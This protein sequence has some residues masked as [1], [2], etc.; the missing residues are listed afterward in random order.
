MKKSIL[1]LLLVAILFYPT[2]TSSAQGNE[3]L[4]FGNPEPGTSEY[5]SGSF[6][7]L[8][9]QM[10]ERERSQSLTLYDEINNYAY[11][12]IRSG[13][14][15]KIVKYFLGD[16]TRPAQR[17]GAT[18]LNI[19]WQSI[20]LGFIDPE[21]GVAYLVTRGQFQSGRP[22]AVTR[23]SLGEGDELP[24]VVGWTELDIDDLKLGIGSGAI[25][26]K[27]GYGYI[28]E[29]DPSFVLFPTIV[30]SGEV[31]MFKLEGENGLPERVGKITLGENERNI[32]NTLV[33]QENM[34][35][36]FFNDI[37]PSSL[38]KYKI[39][40]NG[41]L[42]TR[43]GALEI[44]VSY[45]DS[46]IG[47]I[48]FDTGYGVFLSTVRID[49]SNTII[50]QKIHVG[51]DDDLP[52]LVSQAHAL[53][54]SNV[55]LYDPGSM[56]N[57]FFLE[58]RN[59]IK[60]IQEVQIGDDDSPPEIV[61]FYRFEDIQ[62][63][64]LSNI[65]NYDSESDD[66]TLLIES[67]TIGF[68]NIN[69]L[70]EDDE[71]RITSL[72]A[73]FHFNDF[74]HSIFDP[75][76]DTFYLAR[77]LQDTS[78]VSQPPPFYTNP[79]E[80]HEIR[81]RG[82]SL[83]YGR[84]F[85][86]VS[87][88]FHFDSN[89]NR[90][91]TASMIDSEN[92]LAFMV[93][94]GEPSVLISYRLGD[95][96]S[97]ISHNGEVEI[98]ETESEITGGFIDLKSYVLYLTTDASP[99]EILSY[100]YDPE[101]NNQP[102]FLSNLN[103]NEGQ[104]HIST[105]SFD[106]ENFV[107][108]HATFT[109]PSMIVKVQHLPSEGSMEVV[110]SILLN[111]P[112]PYPYA[113]D[114]DLDNNI[115]I[116]AVGSEQSRIV[117][118]DLGN[119]DGE[120][121]V[122]SS[123]PIETFVN[124]TPVSLLIN[125]NNNEFYLG[126]GQILQRYRYSSFEQS[127]EFYGYWQLQHPIGTMAFTPDMD[128]L[129]VGST[130]RFTRFPPG[131][132][133]PTDTYY[134]PYV[135][136]FETTLQDKVFGDRIH[137][138]DYRKP[139]SLNFYSYEADG[140]LDFAIYRG[141]NNLELIWESGLI[142]NTAEEDFVTV[143]FED[144]FA[145]Q[146]GYYWLTWRTSS[147]RS[148]ASHVPSEADTGFMI[149]H[150]F[151]DSFPE[152]IQLASGRLYNRNWSISLEADYLTPPTP[153]PTPIP[154]PVPS[155][156]PIPTPE[157]NPVWAFTEQSTFTEDSA[158][159]WTFSSPE[160]FN[161]PNGIR[162]NS[163]LEVHTTANLNQ[164]GFWERMNMELPVEVE[165]YE[166]MLT[167]FFLFSTWA[168]SVAN[169]VPTFRLR[170]HSAD[171]SEGYLLAI[172][173]SPSHPSFY[174]NRSGK[175]Y[176]LFWHHDANEPFHHAFDAMR[177]TNQIPNSSMVGMEWFTHRKG[178]LNLVADFR[179]ELS[180]DFRG[181]ESL[182]WTAVHAEPDLLKPELF[183]LSEKGLGIQATE[184][185]SEI[186]DVTFGFWKSAVGGVNSVT[187]ESG[188]IYRAKFTVSSDATESEKIQLPTFR[189]RVNAMNTTNGQIVTG[190]LVNIESTSFDA[191]IATVESPQVYEIWIQIPPE[192]DGN[193]LIFSFDYLYVPGIGND[194][195]MA[196]ILES[197]EVDSFRIPDNQQHLMN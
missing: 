56:D 90:P 170:S 134:N 33:D 177:F 72:P 125:S 20:S 96:P 66:L 34:Y 158:D 191:R 193:R 51:D 82:K 10:L 189:G 169:L 8:E 4:I 138:M 111:E 157:P 121:N 85:P 69:D 68:A 59:Q 190:A 13:S 42:P 124:Q 113:M 16:E 176:H 129:L 140:N 102:E 3:L 117:M 172:E 167:S 188:R 58:T 75:V 160:D 5:P 173:T 166:F 181:G 26:W 132:M 64:R 86:P 19:P 35:V 148:V 186:S 81:L 142:P 97:S 147:S 174:P 187:A 194:P 163:K 136:L 165:P 17:L 151:N 89:I 161:S 146:P 30:R 159:G 156:T 70:N 63:N 52:R 183:F 184:S 149:H 127:I 74:R 182:G 7:R 15:R 95:H 98:V 28:S 80:V 71:I 40:D 22:P 21:N 144:D 152:S 25:D 168:D 196:I 38:V 106:H 120:F 122:F 92:R 145:L 104:D 171:F 46:G 131:F 109:S 60:T 91:I 61:N 94:D 65:I 27:N 79:Q 23:I 84:V 50:F 1:T 103:L 48:N 197:L 164:F 175:F 100:S 76:T 162:E 126:Y 115:G 99:G 57:P 137:L 128:K 49:G 185:D 36:Y 54:N 62:R 6:W 154:T 133:T 143:S 37:M 12:I 2:F 45:I 180:L 195:Q 77:G 135:E 150:Q 110:E 24:K 73:Y 123:F 108:Y 43:I 114:I 83:E 139:T 44:P 105:S 112:D 179:E 41:E 178:D 88:E 39:H 18:Y 118:Y 130:G 32:V 93:A 107:S 31:V 55:V 192:I 153:T 14:N 87:E 101:G 78:N 9:S 53:Q 29:S 11:G 67:E 141:L 47:T 116:I 119:S 155:P